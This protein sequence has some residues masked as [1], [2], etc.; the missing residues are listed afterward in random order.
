MGI[1]EENNAN[2]DVEVWVKNQKENQSLKYVINDAEGNVV[3]DAE[4]NP[5]RKFSDT[6]VD[7]L[8]D[9]MALTATQYA[10]WTFRN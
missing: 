8:T 7:K 3:L 2:V 10:I 9:G 6:E 1:I 5:V 4:G